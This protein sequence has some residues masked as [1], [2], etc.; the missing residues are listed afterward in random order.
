MQ[1]FYQ[2]AVCSKLAE[3]DDYLKKWNF[4]SAVLAF[5]LA[6]MLLFKSGELSEGIRRGLYICSYSVIPAVFP[7]MALSVFICKSS[8]GAFLSEALLPVTKF[9]HLPKACAGVFPAALFGGYPAAAK[10]I[11]DLVSGGFLSSKAAEKMLCFC[12]NA[13]PP[14]L[15]SAVGIGVFGNIK[16][17][18]LLFGAQL[19]SAA[20]IAVFTAFSSK[21]EEIPEYDFIPEIK[22]GAACVTESVISAAE[23]CFRMCAFIVIACGVLELAEGGAAFSSISGSPFFR[24][25]FT[26]FFEVTAGC[27]GCGKIEGFSAIVLAGAIASFS[28]IS[29]MLQVA[30]VTHESG[31]NLVPFIISR[32]FHAG[33]T[34]AFIRLFLSF[35]SEA[36]SVFSVKGSSYEAVLS[37]SAPAA[38]SLLCMASLFLLSLVPPKSEKEPVFS[39]ITHKINNLRHSKTN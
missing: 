34:A 21:K 11:N 33:L 25:A 7:F 5:G 20:V 19:L 12:V 38:V 36:A 28:G 32:F 14:F 29:V 24:A 22:S 31:I 16:T 35:S 26:G 39:R 6:A 37:A 17:G 3:R 15:I 9:L 18:F 27:L 2:G 30:A 23:S 13:G 10:C 4:L 8:A 1:R